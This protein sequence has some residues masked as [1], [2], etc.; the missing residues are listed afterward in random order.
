MSLPKPYYQ[1]DACTIYHGDCREVLRSVSEDVDL[2][3]TDPPYGT[4]GWRRTGRGAGR[5]PAGGLVREAWDDGAVDWLALLPSEVVM[6]F[7]PAARTGSL[8]AA[9]EATGRPKHRTLYWRKPD[10][11]PMFGGR[12]RWS[13]EPVWVLSPD[14]FV[15]KGGDD[16]FE[17]SALRRGQPEYWGHPYQKPLALLSW[18]LA[19]TEAST[20]LDPFA[21]SGST[22]VAAK[23]LGK[24][25]ICIEAE[26][27]YAEIAAKRLAQE[28]L[29]LEVSS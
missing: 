2:T 17:R 14:G 1:D 28:V 8:L 29:P 27:A 11:K 12:T 19:K 15:L 4:G 18:L 6:T 3:L 24:K 26:E 5:N 16:M 21:G 7:W 25:A 9:A 23:G 13:V 22:L 20:V 10:P